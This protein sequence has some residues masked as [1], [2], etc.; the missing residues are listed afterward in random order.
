MTFAAFLVPYS[1]LVI[2]VL[3]VLLAGVLLC[4]YA[5][6]SLPAATGIT[7][8]MLVLLL[9]A[10]ALWQAAVK[11]GDLQRAGLAAPPGVGAREKCLVD[12]G[13]GQLVPFAAWLRV[14][15]P[16]DAIY[17]GVEDTC[18]VYQLLPRLPARPGQRADW[19][20]YPQGLP[21]AERRLL[22]S[23][24]TLPPAQRTVFVTAG[25]LGARR[26]GRSEG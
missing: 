5:G 13:T 3:G 7:G 15:L 14:R 22:R 6:L 19:V 20:V 17:S 23:E 10:P 16:E 9:T 1:T 21:R 11:D 24:R 18:L 8:A 4:R 26:L 25:G 2:E 12:K